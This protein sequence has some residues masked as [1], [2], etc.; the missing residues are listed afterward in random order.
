MVYV[1]SYKLEKGRITE[2]KK[3]E[4]VRV[5]NLGSYITEKSVVCGDGFAAYEKYLPE[6]AKQNIVRISNLLD[7]PHAKSTGL[8]ALQN[9]YLKQPWNHLV[10]LYLRASE[11]EE[12][13]H[14]IK[15]QPLN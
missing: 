6:N 3:P 5:Q 4:V 8:L 2:I 7:E 10:P 11:A 1:A 12:N 15:Y 9:S 13:L 14:G